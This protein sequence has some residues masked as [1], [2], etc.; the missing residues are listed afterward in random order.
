MQYELIPKN[1]YIFRQGEPSKNFFIILKGIISIRKKKFK[2]NEKIM[3][4]LNIMRNKDKE[5]E[6]DKNSNKKILNGK[7]SKIFIYF[8][9]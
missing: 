7:K 4:E 2:V 5:K 8:F 3:R 6:K 9:I 1:T